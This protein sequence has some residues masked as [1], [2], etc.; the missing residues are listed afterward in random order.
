MTGDMTGH[1][2]MTGDNSPLLDAAASQGN[3]AITIICPALVVLAVT[4]LLGLVFNNLP[5]ARS[6]P[7]YW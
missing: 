7:S 1:Q 3:L 2:H 6:Y 4:I 5:P